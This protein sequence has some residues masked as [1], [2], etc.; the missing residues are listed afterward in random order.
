LVLRECV[1]RVGNARLRAACGFA[2]TAAVVLAL[3]GCAVVSVAT[4]ATSLA[5][6]TVTT[7][8][9]VAIGAG[10]LAVQGV[11]AG[12]RAVTPSSTPPPAR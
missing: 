6:G 10:K 8:A 4:T 2:I 9:D 12:I 7:A 1:G 3:P 11:G 5:V